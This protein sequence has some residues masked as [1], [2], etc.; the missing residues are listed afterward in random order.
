MAVCASKPVTAVFL[1]LFTLFGCASFFPPEVQD[2]DWGDSIYQE[3][4]ESPLW[5]K[6]APTGFTS[7][8]R[9]FIFP[10]YA[11]SRIAIRIGTRTSGETSGYFAL[12][13]PSHNERDPE[14][15]ERHA[16]TVTASDLLSLNQLIAESNLWEIYPQHWVRE[17]AV[18]IGGAQL[19]ME[20]VTEAGYRYSEGDA[21]CPQVPCAF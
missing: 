15:T 6:E 21:I 10:A 17:G 5:H 19:I 16:F 14:I 8:I 1:S 12:K 4:G 2:E 18:C 11:Y 7:R 3:F 20:R 9:V 13:R